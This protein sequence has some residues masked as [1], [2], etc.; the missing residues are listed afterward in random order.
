MPILD[1]TY[2]SPLWL[3]N[4]H[5]STIV[6][7]MYRKL[8]RPSYIRERIDTPDGDFLDL[9]WLRQDSDRLVLLSHGLEGNSTRTYMTGMA[10]HFSSLGWDVLAWNCRSCS[11][12][13]NRLPRFYHH[14]DTGDISQ[15]IEHARP[16]Y[17]EVYLIGFSMGGNMALNYLGKLGD[18]APA[19]ISGACVFS[20]PVVLKSSVK[21]LSTRTNRIYRKRFIKKLGEK[22]RKKAE[23]F[24]DVISYEDYET[25]EQFPDF[26]NRYTAPLHGFRDADDFYEQGSPLKSLNNIRRP[27][28]IVNA[29]NDPFLGPEC[30]PLD[31]VSSLEDVYFEMPKRGGHVGFTHK[32]LSNSYMEARASDFH[33]T[34]IKAQ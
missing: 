23:L 11:G 24:P 29:A 18:T 26:D 22:I 12:E 19:E 6:P 27:S 20:V 31:L 30:Y 4:P 3:R 25:I 13:M 21:A 5:L 16:G 10:H 14:A 33:S 17:R 7:S 34:F 28:L 9:D 1:S 15:V 32:R 2:K 8:E